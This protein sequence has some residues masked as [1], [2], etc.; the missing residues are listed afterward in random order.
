M[1]SLAGVAFHPGGKS[2]VTLARAAPLVPFVTETLTSR[3]I[4]FAP[5]A[6]KSGAGI[7]ASGGVTLT[8]KAGTTF[9]SIRLSPL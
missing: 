3:T 6:R 4:G 7:T 2:S 5:A 9:S 1:G 8:E